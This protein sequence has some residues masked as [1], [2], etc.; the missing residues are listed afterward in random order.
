M[1][2]MDITIMI[3]TSKEKVKTAIIQVKGGGVTPSMVRAFCNTVNNLD[4]PGLF[5]AFN[6]NITQG[7]KSIMS[8]AGTF[9]DKFNRKKPKVQFVSVSDVINRKPINL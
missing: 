7:M 5:A 8:E 6:E 2:L 4:K 3:T 1:K 9:K